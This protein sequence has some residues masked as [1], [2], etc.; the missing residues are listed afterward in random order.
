MPILSVVNGSE[1]TYQNNG[2]AQ[3]AGTTF[4]ING[5]FTNLIINDDD[6]NF[7][8]DQAVN[9][10]G[11]D[12]TQT[13]EIG[14]SDVGVVYEYSFTATYGGVTYTFAVID[15]DF[16]NDG[17][18]GDGTVSGAD[19]GEQV[20]FLTV[21]GPSVP[22][23]PPGGA[24]FTVVNPVLDNTNMDYDKF[25]C[26]IAGTQIET[27]TGFMPV[28]ELRPGM[29]V[30]TMD[31]GWQELVWSARR[32]VPGYGAATPVR[33]ATGRLGNKRPLTVSPQHRILLSD[34]RSQLFG[35]SE[36]LFVPAQHLLGGPGVSACPQ[37]EA[38]YVHLLFDAHEVIFAEGAATESLHPIRAI[39]G[40]MGRQ[41]QREILTLF[42]E[43][44]RRPGAYGPTARRCAQGYEARCVI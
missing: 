37:R 41:S 36:A 10:T 7:G 29:R 40:Q 2:L 30:Q 39:S 34:W 9:E 33:F 42:P 32:S 13:A 17:N 21:L 1:T 25:I 8:G 14:G 11:D 18:I 38:D 15:A 23:I 26:F 3:G 28:E 43:L 4:E 44:R 19:A 22:V 5:S 16:N 35:A 12:T 24:T 27:A 6:G 31:N 20:A